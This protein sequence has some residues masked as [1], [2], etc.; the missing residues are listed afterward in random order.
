[1]RFIFL[2]YGLPIILLLVGML[3]GFAK[4]SRVLKTFLVICGVCEATVIFLMVQ[5]AWIDPGVAIA[6]TFSVMLLAMFG[7]WVS[8]LVGFTARRHGPAPI[9]VIAETATTA[10]KAGVAAYNGL[11]DGKKAT[12]RRFGRLGAK[13]VARHTA[14]HLDRR[15][16]GSTAG[17]LRGL[18]K[19]V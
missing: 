11:D 12:L 7:I 9:V 19:L 17:V 3:L 1:M 13:I 2:A 8:V 6:I 4:A 5:G 10:A 14:E 15:G 18:S 16:W